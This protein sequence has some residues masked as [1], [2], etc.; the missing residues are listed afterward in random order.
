[1]D[2]FIFNC[3]SERL[4]VSEEVIE[5]LQKLYSNTIRKKIKTKF[6]SHLVTTIEDLINEK[7]I[8][9]IKENSKNNGND[10]T[11]AKKFYDSRNI[12]FYSL[13]LIPI[14]I[15]RRSTTRYHKFGASIYYNGDFEDKQARILIAHELG[16]VVNREL[17]DIADNEETAN[18]FAYISMQDKSD[19]YKN[20]SKN[21]VFHSD[22]EILN[23]ILNVCGSPKED[24]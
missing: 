6:L 7:R 8:K 15:R 11:L 19:F 10:I 18:L 5:N 13:V 20:E 4:N 1:M 17:S 14:K 22:V 3:L 9:A 2:D 16:H 12:R 24:K 21:Y 23:E